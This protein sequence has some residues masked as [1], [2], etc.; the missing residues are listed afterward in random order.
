MEQDWGVCV[1]I[2][3]NETYNNR[4]LKHR[5]LTEKLYR[6]RYLYIMIIPAILW[7]VFFCYAP[8]YGITVAFKEFKYN[9]GIGGSPW[10]GLENFSKLFRTPAFFEVLKNTIIISFGRILFCFP[11]PIILALMLNELR[12]V[13][14]KKTVQTILYLPHFLSWVIMYGI[15][16]NIL[17]L[18]GGIV[19]KILVYF[20]Y[21]SINFLANADFFRPLVFLSA[22]WKDAGWGT[23]VYLAALAGINPELYEAAKIDGAGRFRQ[24]TNVTWPQ[25]KGTVVIML[26]LAS[27]N[28]MNAGF[29][30]IFNLYNP[31]VYSKGDILDT[32][33]YRITIL[34]S[35]YGFGT[36]VGLFK[37]VINCFILFGVNRISRAL[38]STEIY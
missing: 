16:Y 18:D 30:Q 7:Y 20:G 12:R 10:I 9:A 29:D 26:I 17:S 4:A 32:Y 28:I 8:M 25:L 24:L 11:V 13:K 1:N 19:N 2:V 36:A 5:R 14:I 38:G 15:I 27:G 37:S 22:I 34:N 31:T 35:E 6:Y 23:I 21:E 3:G 33:I